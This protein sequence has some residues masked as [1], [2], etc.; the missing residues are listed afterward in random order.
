MTRRRTDNSNNKA[1]GS[2]VSPLDSLV[3]ECGPFNDTP[4]PVPEFIYVT[5]AAFGCKIGRT[6]R[7]ELRS[8]QVTGNAPIELEV[9]IVKEV[10]GS[11]EIEKNL[12]SY[13]K[14]KWI[15]GEWYSLDDS[16]IAFI[17]DLLDG[18][19]SFPEPDDDFRFNYVNGS[20]CT[21]NMLRTKS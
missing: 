9:L 19:A 10:S 7:P 14:E 2:Y 20:R 15:R 12:H 4:R 5:K 16:D 8:L 1:K 21:R 11:R 6:T 18:K 17:C 13:F 3:A